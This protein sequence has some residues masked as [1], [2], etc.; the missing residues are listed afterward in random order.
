MK[1]ISLSR[2][3]F[4]LNQRNLHLPK[5]LTAPK[6]DLNAVTQHRKGQASCQECLD[7]VSKK[8]PFKLN[9]LNND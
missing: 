6:L 8:E 3:L 4:I 2:M 7:P 9:K 1:Q 5:T